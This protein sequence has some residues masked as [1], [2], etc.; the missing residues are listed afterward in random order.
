MDI[1][2]IGIP[3]LVFIVL[4]ALVVLG[5]KEMQK[6]G[7]LIGKQLRKIVTS[8]E[9]RAV[10]DASQEARSLPDKWMREAGIEDLQ[11]ELGIDK[12]LLTETGR[13]K[14]VVSDKKKTGK[15]PANDEDDKKVMA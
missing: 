4:I 10:K 9:W 12:D 1:L 5:P 13:P 14:F 7:K 15:P 8:P 3:E 11:N 2:G 6:T